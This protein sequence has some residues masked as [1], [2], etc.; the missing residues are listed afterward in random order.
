MDKTA[1]IL[2]ATVGIA[3]KL[4]NDSIPGQ[5]VN[6]YGFTRDMMGVAKMIKPLKPVINKVESTVKNA[7]PRQYKPL[8]DKF[9]KGMNF[10]FNKVQ[11]P[12]GLADLGVQL[13]GIGGSKEIDATRRQMGQ[14]KNLNNELKPFKYNGVL[15]DMNKTASVS[16]R[17]PMIQKVIESKNS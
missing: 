7:I 16:S 11:L 15:G 4:V 8:A 5:I 6:A 3:N 1:N 2:G 12:V 17:Y 13:T 9:D 10:A 14:F